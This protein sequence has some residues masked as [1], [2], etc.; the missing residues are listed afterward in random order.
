[1]RHEVKI[2]PP[3]LNFPKRISLPLKRPVYVEHTRWN[4]GVENNEVGERI[5]L[6]I[7]IVTQNSRVATIHDIYDSERLTN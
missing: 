2:R 3:I 5:Q 6:S 4:I 7:D 1:M